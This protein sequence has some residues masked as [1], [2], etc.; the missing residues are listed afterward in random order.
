MKK[1]GQEKSTG[2]NPG[3]GENAERAEAAALC[4]RR[5]CYLVLLLM[6]IA[7]AVLAYGASTTAYFP[8]DLR[9]TRDLQAVNSPFFNQL[10]IWTS[11]PGYSPQS[12]VLTLLIG[13][14]LYF[15]G[16]RWEA[17][18]AVGGAGFVEGVNALIKFII[19][20][21]RPVSDLV[22]VVNV[23]NS[24]SFPS[25]HVMYYTA[26]LGFIWFLVFTLLRK[27]WLRTLSLVVSGALILL[28]GASRV[29]LGQHWTSDVAGAYL[30]GSLVLV[31][32]I[33]VYR[34]GKRMKFFQPGVQ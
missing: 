24:Y 15:F 4:L 26:F 21:P 14:A 12:I 11:W 20:R 6:V 16:L 10:M 25:G 19:H 23:L 3:A 8:I 1:T 33:H 17:L 30:L 7:F 32:M 28:V 13:G 9:L 5:R 34:W 27:S 18:V 31:L 29:Y 22:H 2:K